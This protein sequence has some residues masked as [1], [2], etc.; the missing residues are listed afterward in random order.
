MTDMLPGL[1]EAP[2]ALGAAP[3]A[4]SLMRQMGTV[5]SDEEPLPPEEARGRQHAVYHSWVDLM[6]AVLGETALALLLDDVHWSDPLTLLSLARFLES[7]PKARLAVILTARHIPVREDGAAV[8]LLSATEARIGPLSDEEVREF[9]VGAGLAGDE[10]FDEVTR[11]L[12]RA[13][14][15]NPLFLSHLVHQYQWHREFAETPHDLA[16]LID[17]QL[18]A[19]SREATRLLQACALLGQHASL[20]RIE[21]A[22][23]VEAPSLVSAF[24][25]LDDMLA[26]PA[27]PGVPLAPHDL[28]TERVRRGMTSGVFRSL[29]VSVARVLEAD[30]VSDGAIELSW[31]AA[32]LYWE[33]GEKQLAYAT[34]MR[35]AEYLLRTGAPI[36]SARAFLAASEWAPTPAQSIRALIGR[37]A[38]F[39]CASDWEECSKTVR[40]IHGQDLTSLSR[41]VIIDFELLQLQSDWYSAADST[42]VIERLT[43]FISQHAGSDVTLTKAALVGLV[44][45]D[46]MF[47]TE[48][49]HRFHAIVSACEQD[50]ASAAYMK[51]H[52][53]V[54]YFTSTGALDRAA[55]A[56]K[57]LV[58]ISRSDQSTPGLI[59]ALRAA[60]YPFR[61]AGD[62]A[63]ARA[64]LDEAF[65]LATKH[66]FSHNLRHTIEASAWLSIDED[67]PL[68]AIES[69]CRL[70]EAS[71]STEGSYLPL[72]QIVA[73]VRLGRWPEAEA[74]A[75]MLEGHDYDLATRARAMVVAA[76]LFI[77]THQVDVVACRTLSSQITKMGRVIFQHAGQDPVAEAFAGGLALSR[78]AEEAREFAQWYLH[79]AR[80]ERFPA[81]SALVA[82]AGMRPSTGS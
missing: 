31:D 79:S 74:L 73:N 64:Y 52:A 59:V 3:H 26:L 25:E 75:L 21:R 13:S 11:R 66:A 36:N 9:A 47:D 55:E 1:L 30:A 23:G 45:A 62:F 54:V 28:W 58:K 16:S 48:A 71:R 39:Q 43:R 61:R 46:N 69:L 78:G 2:G 14:G 20:P 27:D 18:R 12:G 24:G 41:D 33:S 65:A 10:R 29:A 4:L 49:L 19:L 34:M 60:A 22:L 56:A 80:I 37:A 70:D 32:R 67:D 72:A 6:D 82:I 42:S 51:I 7:R 8:R 15:G 57:D 40:T 53:D 77:A 5:K 63:Q 68:S 81:P 35:C 50:H 38:S 76:R 44:A 17:G